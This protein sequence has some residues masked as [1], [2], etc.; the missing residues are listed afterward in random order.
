MLD[1]DPFSEEVMADP[2]PMY[3]RLR[4]ESP[5]HYLEKYDSW[6]L[7]R[8]DD[9]WN[10]SMD[11]QHLSATRGTSS[12]YLLTKTIPALPNLNHM[13]PPQQTK[14]RVAM[15]SYFMPRHV[16]SLESTIRGYVTDFGHRTPGRT[17]RYSRQHEL[18][19]VG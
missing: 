10:A 13:D 5:V 4:A 14:L 7:A 17:R 19:R 2:Y 12:P 11:D 8:F 3:A 16:R 15:A 6:A 1:Y 18:C 9:I